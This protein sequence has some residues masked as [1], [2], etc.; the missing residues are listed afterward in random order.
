MKKKKELLSKEGERRRR[1]TTAAGRVG[2]SST[3]SGATCDVL[4][5]VGQGEEQQGED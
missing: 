3:A 2:T 4:I 5:K 1:T